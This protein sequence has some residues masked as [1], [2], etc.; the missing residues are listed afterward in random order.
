VGAPQQVSADEYQFSLS[1]SYSTD[2]EGYDADWRHCTMS[3]ESQDGIGPPGSGAY[4]C[5]S[6][7]IQDSWYYLG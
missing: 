1:F 6:P 5:D 3:L 7:T 4:G 2:N